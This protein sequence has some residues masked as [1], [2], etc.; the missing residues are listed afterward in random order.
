MLRSSNAH[1]AWVLVMLQKL[2]SLC[3]MAMGAM[4]CHIGYVFS[5]GVLNTE[6]LMELIAEQAM[7]SPPSRLCRWSRSVTRRLMTSAP[8]TLSGWSLSEYAHIW[9]VCL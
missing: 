3:L 1:I 6:Y 5:A 8:R 2:S 9:D 7:R 4:R